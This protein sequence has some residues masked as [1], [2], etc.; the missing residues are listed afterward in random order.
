MSAALDNLIQLLTL[1]K[2]DENRFQGE[3]ENIG[4]P[5]IFGGQIF[6]QGL[7]AAME[8]VDLDRN[9]HSCHAY[10]LRPGDI[11]FPV[12]YETE[13][14]RE[15]NS[16]TAV[17]VIAKQKDE[18][19]CRLMTSFHLDEEGFEHQIEMKET[20]KPEDFHSENELV[21]AMASLMP[22]HLRTHFEKERPFDVRVKYVNDP[23]N[24][25]ELPPKQV[26]WAKTNGELKINNRR[27]QKCLFAYFSDF[28]CLRTSLHPHGRGI[29][30]RGMKIGTLDHGIWFHRDFD[31]SDWILF[32]LKSNN[33]AKARGFTVGKAFDKQG[34]LIASIEQEGLIR[35]TEPKKKPR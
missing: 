17:S 26:V 6:A 29:F 8:V 9:L 15:G 31:L 12:I 30:Q 16:F 33:A 13:V 19:L 32:E 22:K 34:N 20:L 25:M 24:G 18:E 11:H 2:L 5:K 28:H 23:F 4:L 7:A 27:L 14:L 1:T 21:K 3:S 10:F 35:Y